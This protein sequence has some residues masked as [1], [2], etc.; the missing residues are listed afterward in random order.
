MRKFYILGLVLTAVAVVGAVS[1]V[2]A[3]ALTFLLAEWLESGV[4][5]TATLLAQAVGEVELSEELTVLGVK[6]KIK[7]LCS[8]LGLG[9]VGPDG[10]G[11]I[12]E[13]LKF[14]GGNC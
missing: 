6:I 13:V 9:F 8:I 1:A 11:E 10:A 2:S 4:G 12:T 7:V 5:I 3:S 14:K